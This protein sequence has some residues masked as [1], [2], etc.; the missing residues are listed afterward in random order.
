MRETMGMDNKE[1]FMIAGIKE[2]K[3]IFIWLN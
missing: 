3:I 1:V 2:A